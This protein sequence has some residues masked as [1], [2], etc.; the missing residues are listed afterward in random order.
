ME[1]SSDHT[2]KS[3]SEEE[4]STHVDPVLYHRA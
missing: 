2:S 4:L 3:T 1:D